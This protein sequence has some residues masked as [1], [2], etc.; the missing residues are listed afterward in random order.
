LYLNHLEQAK[1][2]LE[3]NPFPLP[4]LQ[5]KRQPDSLFDYVFEDFEFIN[6]QCHP[7][8]KAPIAV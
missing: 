1:T 7:G 2:Q 6:Y 8:I 5:I 3:R 4:Q